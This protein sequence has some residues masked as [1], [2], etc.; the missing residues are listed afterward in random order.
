[1]ELA[2]QLLMAISISAC[3]GLRTF[4]PLLV[5][6]LLG[7]TGHVELNPTF[8]FL[9]RNESLTVLGIAAVLELLGDKFIAVDH[10]LDTVGTVARPVAG[11]IAAGSLLLRLDPLT[12]TAVALVLGGGGALTVHLGK[13]ALRYKSSALAPLHAG[14]GNSALSLIEDAFSAIWLLIAALAPLLGFLIT[15]AAIGTAAWLL[16]H[17]FRTGRKLFTL[18]QAR[19]SP[20][21][22]QVASKAQP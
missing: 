3:A 2:A 10:F 8:E 19:Y 5:I 12:A 7:R 16:V 18:L 22:P 11:T 4:L 6:G 21:R 14:L 1:V 15:L 13:A 20:G 9:A 17:F